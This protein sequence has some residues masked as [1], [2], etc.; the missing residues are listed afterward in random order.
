[1]E[2]PVAAPVLAP[3]TEPVALQRIE[4]AGGTKVVPKP[5]P[6]IDQPGSAKQSKRGQDSAPARPMKANRAQ[7][8]RRTKAVVVAGFLL[9]LAAVAA[10][11]FLLVTDPASGTAMIL[12]P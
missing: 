7:P 2:N 3:I 11:I 9:A 1:L 8:S 6:K 10:G 12:N 5:A 4:S